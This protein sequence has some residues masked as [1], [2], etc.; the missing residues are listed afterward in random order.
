MLRA[1]GGGEEM[2]E[3]DEG[4]AEE[5]VEVPHTALPAELLQAVLE[6]FVTREGTDYG[7]ET[8]TLAQKTAMVLRQLERKKAVILWDPQ[9]QSV[10]IHPRR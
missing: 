1:K 2:S 9:T 5:P 6:E 8:F 7:D 4:S 10:Q 3:M